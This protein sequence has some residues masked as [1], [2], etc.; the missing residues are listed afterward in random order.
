MRKSGCSKASSV[1]SNMRPRGFTATGRRMSGPSTMAESN[2]TAERADGPA[3]PS[4]VAA[5]YALL[6]L[7]CV[8]ALIY[9][10]WRIG[11]VNTAYPVYSWIVYAA[12]VVGFARALLFLRSVVRLTH[13]EPPPAP[14]GLRVDVFVPTYDEPVEVV[15]RTVL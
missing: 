10:T 7:S 2:G 1:T 12:E 11:V 3:S 6:L 13:N 9:F 4:L 5:R 14:S 8:T 15:R